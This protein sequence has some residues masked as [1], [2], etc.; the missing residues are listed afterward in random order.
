MDFRIP[1]N[2][3]IY[4]SQCLERLPP[5]KPFEEPVVPKTDMNVLNLLV[6]NMSVGLRRHIS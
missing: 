4:P 5:R 3:E 6:R 2:H 1:N